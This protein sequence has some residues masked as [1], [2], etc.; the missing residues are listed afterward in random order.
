MNTKLVKGRVVL[1]SQEDEAWF[2]EA[3][4]VQPDQVDLEA[5]Q[6]IVEMFDEDEQRNILAAGLIELV[7]LLISKG[8]ITQEELSQSSKDAISVWETKI[9]PIR[10]AAKTAKT[11]K[12]TPVWPQ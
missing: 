1:F 9:N 7:D 8:V 2:Q 6:K 12:T 4:K 5:R 11:N 3:N 10:A